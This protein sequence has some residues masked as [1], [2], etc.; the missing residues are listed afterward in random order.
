M[1]ALLSIAL[2]AFLASAAQAADEATVIV[3]IAADGRATVT[4]ATLANETAGESYA[5]DLVLAQ[6]FVVAE[7]RVASGGVDVERPRQL[8]P[9]Y[10]DRAQ[11]AEVDHLH[12]HFFTE[13]P[14]D[15]AAD[16][17]AR[18]FNATTTPDGF[19][20]RLGLTGPGPARLLLTRDVTPPAYTLGNV[21]DVNHYRFIFRTTT[22]E[23]AFGDL[24]VRPAAGGDEVPNPTTVPAIE[25]TYPVQGLKAATDYVFHVT[26]TDWAGN[27]VRSEE[28]TARTTPE[29][30]LPTPVV[31]SVLPANGSRLPVV[32]RIE[33][34]FRSSE[35]VESG[36]VVLFIDKKAIPEIALEQDG[37]A[38]G[39][40][41][42]TYVPPQALAP[43]RH[44]AAI[45]IR[46]DLG[47]EALARWTFEVGEADAP[48]AGW[49][50]VAALVFVAA[51]R[52]RRATWD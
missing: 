9:E 18:V 26:F 23:F 48:L 11:H 35:P 20:Q 15:I 39:G 12:P 33:V 37:S 28:R 36:G 3:D 25:Q 21:T 40:W 51:T 16:D 44:S 49:F 19:V 52:A 8:M 5:I 50:V 31:T 46:N 6:D 24:R 38:V 4:G 32:D 14:R 7:V 13:V 29:P 17:G 45:E 10:D 34:R 47:G 2:L 27:T 1:R 42:A 43:G 30:V 41:K 22:D